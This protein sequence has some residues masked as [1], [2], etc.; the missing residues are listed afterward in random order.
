MKLKRF[1]PTF[2]ASRSILLS[3]ATS[4]EGS[5]ARSSTDTPILAESGAASAVSCRGPSQSD[6]AAE[7]EGR[8]RGLD[9]DGQGLV[10]RESEAVEEEYADLPDLIVGLTCAG[11]NWLGGGD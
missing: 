5:V 8:A 7:E 6:G 1:S 9:V 11:Y 2:R 10:R 4:S 3:A